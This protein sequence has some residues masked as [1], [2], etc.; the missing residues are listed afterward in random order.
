VSEIRSFWRNAV[1]FEVDVAEMPLR[2]RSSSYVFSQ[3][4]NHLNKVFASQVNQM[5]LLSSLIRRARPSL[6]LQ[7]AFDR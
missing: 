5:S 4:Q 6:T 1:T 3:W 2:L 7:L